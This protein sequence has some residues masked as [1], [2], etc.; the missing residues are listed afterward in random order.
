MLDKPST[1]ERA[2]EA[3]EQFEDL[4]QAYLRVEDVKAQIDTLAPLPRL[5]A[6]RDVAESAK[7]KAEAMSEALPAVRAHMVAEELDYQIR[8]LNAQLTEAQSD[9]E[10][11]EEEVKHL[12]E[13]ERLAAVAAVSYTHLTLPTIYSV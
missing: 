9:T 6:Q 4:R 10:S 11:L 7:H 8:A 12:D 13:A 2:D 1:F 5:H 3:V